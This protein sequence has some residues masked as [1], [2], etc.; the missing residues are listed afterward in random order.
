M[1]ETTFDWAHFT[2]QRSLKESFCSRIV[3]ESFQNV[4]QIFVQIIC[5]NLRVECESS[6]QHRVSRLHS[7]W[8]KHTHAGTHTHTHTHFI[9]I[10]IIII[11][12]S[13][14]HHH[15]RHR[16]RGSSFNFC[17]HHNAKRVRPP[18][19]RSTCLPPPSLQTSSYAPLPLPVAISCFLSKCQF[20]F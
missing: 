16:R 4:K 8:N 10:N 1:R 13:S 11:T 3:D 19:L 12:S 6:P 15:L 17:S 9:I 20:L 7:F 14:A 18:Q 2:F 5:A